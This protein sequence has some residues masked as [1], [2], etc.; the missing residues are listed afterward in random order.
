MSNHK[1]VAAANVVKGDFIPKDVIVRVMELDP[2][3]SEGNYNWARLNFNSYLKLQIFRNTGKEPVIKCE[4]DGLRVLT[5]SE[6]VEYVNEQFTLGIRKMLRA[7][8]QQQQIDVSN[9]TKEEK[10]RNRTL[11]NNQSM[12]V[13]SVKRVIEKR[14]I[15]GFDIDVKADII[16]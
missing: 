3:I 11:L 12:V 7:N 16:S 15:L 6:A 10:D 8:L 9:L 4:G 14:K 13:D 2:N 1:L 5:D